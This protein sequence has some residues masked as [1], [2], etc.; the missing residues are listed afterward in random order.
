MSC[1]AK[2][3][4]GYLIVSIVHLETVQRVVDICTTSRVNGAN[5]QVTQIC[6]LRDFLYQQ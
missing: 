2:I 5:V 1:S 3:E 4:L 6:P